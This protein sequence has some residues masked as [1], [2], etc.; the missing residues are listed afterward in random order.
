MAL[1]SRLS[2]RNCR[3]MRP[4]EAPRAARKP[5]SCRR[6]VNRTSRRFATLAHA[7]T[8][9]SPDGG[10][11]RQQRRARGADNVVAQRDGGQRPRGVGIAR[12]RGGKP[13]RQHVELAASLL[14]AHA[15]LQTAD[16]LQVTEAAANG[17]FGNPR[18]LK[19]SSWSRHPHPRTPAA[20][21]RRRSR[22]RWRPSSV[23]RA[24]DD[25][26]D[27]RRSACARASS[28]ITATSVPRSSSA[29]KKRPASGVAPKVS[30]NALV[31]ERAVHLHRVPLP[32]SASARGSVIAP[33]R[34]ER[35]LL[36]AH[37]LELRHREPE[38]RDVALEILSPQAHQ[39]LGLLQP[40]RREERRVD[41][42]E[43]RGVGADAKASV[44]TAMAAKPGCF[45]KARSA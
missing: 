37:Q 6:P 3:T 24:A 1:S 15:R 40:I 2:T 11:Q 41:D 7:T 14:L 33:N 16:R 22:C 42:A 18:V 30:R 9:S 28:P 13:R 35:R 17:V 23:M 32:T 29:R 44:S 43:D 39:P 20:A 26:P 12:M 36:I 19:R 5:I 8:S 21:A 34:R 31:D 10:E 45:M 27:R 38:L 4:R 25:R